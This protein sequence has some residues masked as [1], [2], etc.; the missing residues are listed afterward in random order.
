M[1]IKVNSSD[2]THQIP[3]TSAR[4]AANH[5]VRGSLSIADRVSEHKLLEEV[6][7]AQLN[8]F[9]HTFLPFC[10]FVYIPILTTAADLL[11]EKPFLWLVIMSMTTRSMA[12]QRAMGDTICQIVAQNVVAKHEKSLD[13]LLGLICYLNWS[14]MCCL[15][16][17]SPPILNLVILTRTQGY[18]T[19]RKINYTSSCGPN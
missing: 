7:E 10:P 3:P 12:E 9:I 5:N 4:A 11:V 13:L 16:T 2:Y 17:N 8:A 15:S 18:I 1:A 19:T 6:A 14:V